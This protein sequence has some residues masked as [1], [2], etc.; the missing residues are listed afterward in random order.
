M[1]FVVFHVSSLLVVNCHCEIFII[2][3]SNKP[4]YC[5]SQFML[6]MMKVMAVSK[7]FS[8]EQNGNI[9]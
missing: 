6:S 7:I 4:I 9:I 2:L 8:V 1:C 3:Y 5:L